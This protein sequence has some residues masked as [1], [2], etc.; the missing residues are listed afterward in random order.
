MTELKRTP[1]L[2]QGVEWQIEKA[3]FERFR[4]DSLHFKV[5]FKVPVRFKGPVHFKISVQF[6]MSKANLSE[7]FARPLAFQR[8]V[9]HLT[10]S[11]LERTHCASEAH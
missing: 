2:T 11:N 10:K 3:Q 5:H 8:F 1:R 6:A 7:L 9:I 4:K